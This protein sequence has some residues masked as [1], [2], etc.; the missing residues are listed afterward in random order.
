MKFQTNDSKRKKNHGKSVHWNQ[1]G[2]KQTPV[3]IQRVYNKQQNDIRKVAYEGWIQKGDSNTEKVNSNFGNIK[4]NKWN[5]K[6]GGK[7]DRVDRMEDRIS[8][9]K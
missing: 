4:L 7:P 9:I 2:Q 3:W 1:E 6:L 8:G 5:K